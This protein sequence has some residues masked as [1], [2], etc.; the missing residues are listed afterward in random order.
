MARWRV[1]AGIAVLLA[2]AGF[3]GLLFRPY[4]QNWRLQQYIE[5]MAF[6]ESRRGQDVAAYVV[7][8]AN[9]A[10]RLGLPVP[11]DHIR[12]TKSEDGVYI[13][14]RYF[15]RV[16]LLLYTVDLHFRPSAGVR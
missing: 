9:Q 10:S 1:A 11:V 3:C 6:D 14:A 5:Q 4:L 16:D 13:E 2:L 8:V 7:A 12:V 15:V